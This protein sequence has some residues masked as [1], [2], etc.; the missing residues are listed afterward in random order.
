MLFI[1]FII[2][3]S[4]NLYGQ[5]AEKPFVFPHK[6][7][8]IF[9]YFCE[10]GPGW[11]DTLQIK[12]VFDS[13]DENGVIHFIQKRWLLNPYRPDDGY[14]GDSAKYWLDTI[15]QTIYGASVTTDSTLIIKLDANKGD[16]FIDSLNRVA[17]KVNDKWEEFLWGNAT[18]FMEFIIYDCSFIEQPETWNDIYWLDIA[19]GYGVV[20]RG[21]G[22]SFSIRGA[23]INGIAYGDTT[24]VTFVRNNTNLPGSIKLNQNYPNPFNPSTTIS[25][26][27]RE[28]NNISLIIYDVTGR[29]VKRLIDNNE[30]E[31]GEHKIMWYGSNESNN[32]VSSGVY[33]YRLIAGEAISTRSM[34][35]MK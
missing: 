26:E 33:F 4:I 32:P 18:A 15:N 8:D 25:F 35:L 9:E 1:I 12:T 21:S 5:E 11:Y 28:R 27:I 24:L 3:I 19:D 14:I 2:F 20:W 7:G 23:V 16:I 22:W 10:D 34:I 31:A 17:V 13:T 30:Y 6:T 29:E